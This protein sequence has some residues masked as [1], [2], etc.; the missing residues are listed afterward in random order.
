MVSS[1]LRGAVL[2]LAMQGARMGYWIG[3]LDR[4][5][6]RCSH[7]LAT[8][9]GLAGTIDWPVDA[10]GAL[11]HPADRDGL[12]SA[13][14]RATENGGTLLCGF[15]GGP[16]GA[17]RGREG[18]GGRV[19]ARRDRPGRT[20]IRAWGPAATDAQGLYAKY[21]FVPTAPNP[22]SMERRLKG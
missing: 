11:R 16:D 9:L 6:M 18:A 2:H 14:V 5:T 17:V 1:D 22:S 21:G 19:R 12:R 15:R 8:L 3:D 4:R 20:A 10:C 13:F 7:E